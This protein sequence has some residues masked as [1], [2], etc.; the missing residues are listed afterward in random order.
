MCNKMWLDFLD[1]AVGF[2]SI[3]LAIGAL[4]MFYHAVEE[5]VKGRRPL[6]KFLCIKGIISLMFFQGVVVSMLFKWDILKSSN[7]AEESLLE[8]GIESS[9]SV[10]EMC[11]VFTF[12]FL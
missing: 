9:L 1:L 10:V 3:S 6:V 2:G 5:E 11:L 7:A 8:N 12:A 4:L